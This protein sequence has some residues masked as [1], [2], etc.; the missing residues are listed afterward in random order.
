M[1][2]VSGM[3]HIYTATLWWWNSGI[4]TNDL[5]RYC[6]GFDSRY[7]LWAPETFRHLCSKGSVMISGMGASSCISS[8]IIWNFGNHLMSTFCIKRLGKLEMASKNLSP[9]TY[10]QHSA[11]GELPVHGVR[12]SC[13]VWGQFVARLNIWWR[14][15]NNDTWISLKGMGPS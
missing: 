10:Q 15:D 11:C 6:K 1:H 9:L 2:V 14:I 13:L 12:C 8:Q 7:S 3:F 5:W 4:S